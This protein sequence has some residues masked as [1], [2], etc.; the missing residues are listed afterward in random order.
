MTGVQTCALPISQGCIL[1]SL[2]LSLGYV[3]AATL[4]LHHLPVGPSQGLLGFISPSPGMA[5]LFPF[6]A[7]THPQSVLLG[8]P[9][10]PTVVT[11][12]PLIP[13]I[14][15]VT[16]G[17]SGYERCSLPAFFSWGRGVAWVLS[18][19]SF[20]EGGHTVGFQRLRLGYQRS[21]PPPRPPP[22]TPLPTSS[23][24]SDY[25]SPPSSLPPT[26]LADALLPSLSCRLE[27]LFCLAATQWG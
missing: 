8:V 7:V 21:S 20:L 24:S 26:L 18:A 11:P 1:T 17:S 6:S 27:P 2:V 19:S 23:S 16:P 10:P 15:D 14:G 25:C 13:R 9:P 12:C 4:S 5:T 22:A 3:V